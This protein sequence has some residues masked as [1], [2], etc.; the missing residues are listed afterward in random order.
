MIFESN[1]SPALIH[2]GYRQVIAEG[3]EARRRRQIKC[4][5]GADGQSWVGW[6]LA[7]AKRVYLDGMKFSRVG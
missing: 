7:H 2:P 1:L 5:S 6:A 4:R 3:L